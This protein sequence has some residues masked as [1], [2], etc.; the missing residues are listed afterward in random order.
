MKKPSEQNSTFP[1]RFRELMD[2][3][4]TTQEKLSQICDVTRQAISQWR[5]GITRPDLL[6]L[7]KIAKYFSV[8]TDYLLGLTDV[9]TTDTATKELC[10][11]LGLSE[12]AIK[13]L[14]G[15]DKLKRDHLCE[16]VRCTA[17]ILNTFGTDIK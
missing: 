2:Q 17:I 5:N 6:Y 9:K 13:I 11:T 15:N 14:R 4:H 1:T 8:S 3:T 16:V 7:T 10:S 12:E